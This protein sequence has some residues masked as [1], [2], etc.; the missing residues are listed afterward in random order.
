MPSE[1]TTAPTSAAKATI[2]AASDWRTGSSSCFYQELALRFAELGHLA[3]A[4][5]YFGRTAGAEH[6]IVT[7]PGAP[8]SFF[9]RTQEQFAA[10]SQD[11]WE[12]T[13]AFVAA[14]G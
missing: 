5:D 1:T 10:E 14:H 4:I 11:A 2:A 8:H 3:L 12:R 7:Y 9:D 6:G 13:L